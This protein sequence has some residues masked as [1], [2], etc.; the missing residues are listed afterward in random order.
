MPDLTTKDAMLERMVAATDGLD[1]KFGEYLPLAGGT[2]TGTITE[3]QNSPSSRVPVVIKYTDLTNGTAPDS[4]DG[5]YSFKFVDKNDDAFGG[6]YHNVYSAGAVGTRLIARWGT[7]SRNFE[8][9]TGAANTYFRCLADDT[10]QLGSSNY[11]WKEVY[12]AN[13]TINTSDERVKDN[14]ES[15]PDEVLDAWGDVEWVQ[16]QFKDAIKNKDKAARIHI[17][18]IAQ[19]IIKVFAEH[20]LDAMRYG[21]VCYDAWEADE[22]IPAG[23]LYGLRYEEA[24]CLESAYQRRE[25]KR[26]AERI[27]ALETKRSR[28]K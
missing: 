26:L 28:K 16:Y 25:L 5:G 13:G 11:R 7:T 19:R 24:L 27:E 9:Y 14:I 23:E 6:L 21:V 18:L 22:N 12:A 2:M 10:S 8:F 3:E 15:I 20:G 17:G 4:N 1:E